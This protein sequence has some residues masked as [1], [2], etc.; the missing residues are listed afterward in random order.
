MAAK[1]F[2]VLAFVILACSEAK[3]HHKHSYQEQIQNERLWRFEAGNEYNFRYDA[4]TSTGYS[5]LTISRQRAI[6]RFQSLIQITF[7]TETEATFSMRQIRNVQ[8]NDISVVNKWN[9]TQLQPITMF[10]HR[11]FES[12]Q[13]E[14]EEILKFNEYLSL[15]VKF[16][17]TEE[18]TIEAIRF[19]KSEPTATKNIKKAVLNLIQVNLRSATSQLDE[20]NEK[21]ETKTNSSRRIENEESLNLGNVGN[22]YTNFEVCF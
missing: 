15:P 11:V 16:T 7:H 10:E 14:T 8:L 2:L 4:Q 21:F 9:P 20:F 6:N 17:F 19:K 3:H 5:S 13:D 1:A 12:Q 18:G 22:S